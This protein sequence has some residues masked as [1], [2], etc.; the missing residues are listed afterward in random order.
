VGGGADPGAQARVGERGVPTW[1]ERYRELGPR[2]F[3]RWLLLKR[4]GRLPVRALDALMARSSLVGTPILF[5]PRAFR[6]A[7]ELEA[8]WPAIRRELDAVLETRA[9][10]PAFHEIQPDQYRINPDR[11]WNVFFFE[12]LGRRSRRNRALCPE[13]ARALDRVAGVELAF[14]SILA[15]GLHI[16][17]HSGITKALIRCHLGL[18]V[19]RD[20]G[21]CFMQ[22]GRERFHWEEGR[23]VVFDDTHPHEVW[24]D[25]DEERVVLLVDVERPM[26]WP[27]RLAWRSVRALL[28]ASP[29]VRDG[30]RNQRDWEERIAARQ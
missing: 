8:A 16:P 3:A 1:R 6:C 5:D 30:W 28:R 24:N 10:L 27:G 17:R 22:I 7:A 23:A 13:T 25:T 15:P 26:R 9:Q 12:G 29:F 4:V 19:P 20:A 11:R 14:F 21:K 2:R 18:K